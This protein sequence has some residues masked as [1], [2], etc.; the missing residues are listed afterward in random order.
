MPDIASLRF[1]IDVGDISKAEESLDRLAQ[2]GDKAEQA[3]KDLSQSWTSVGQSSAY[4]ATNTKAT[5]D[6]F[7]STASAINSTKAAIGGV[8]ASFSTATRSAKQTQQALAQLPL[9]FTDIFTSLASGQAP[10]TV[11]IQQGGQIKDSFGGVG[12]ALRETALYARTLV[13]PLTL[14]AAAAAAL[15]LAYKQGSEEADA[16]NKAIITTGNAAGTTANELADI[17]RQVDGVVGTQAKAADVLAQLASTGK[18]AADQ[19]ELLTTAAVAYEQATGQAVED[20]I[21]QYKK[22][23]EDPVEAALKLNE[24]LNFLTPAIYDQIVALEEQGRTAE[25]AA[26]A[27]RAL[28]DEQTQRAQELTDQLGYIQLA[29]KGVTDAAKEGWDAILDVG[30]S[31]TEAQKIDRLR[32]R[33]QELEA[34]RSSFGQALLN[35]FDFGQ[36]LIGDNE[37]QIR[38]Q[39]SAIEAAQKAA[40][41]AADQEAKQAADNKAYFEQDQENRKKK[42][43]AEKQFAQLVQ[44]NLTK[45]QKLTAEIANIRA[46]GA[47]AGVGK[48]EIEAQVRAAEARFAESLPKGRTARTPV[49]RDDAATKLLA[50]LREQEAALSLQLTTTDKL[51]KAEQDRVKFEQQITD[52]KTKGQLTAEQQSLLNNQDAIRAQ[53]DKNVAIEQEVTLRQKAADE[54][55]KLA[56]FEGVLAD[57]MQRA[58]DS[59]ALSLEGVGRGDKVQKQL[60]EQLKIQQD[61]ANEQSKLQE[62]FN[63]GDISQDLYDKETQAL[64]RALDERLQLQQDYYAKDAA[65]RGD[66]LNGVTKSFEDYVDAANDVSGQTEQL[67]TKALGGIEDEFVS[68]ATTGKASFRD[69]ADSILADIAR[70]GVRTLIGNAIGGATGQGGGQGIDFGSIASAIGSFF[71]GGRATGGSVSAGKFYEVGEGN[72]PELLMAGG[73][74]Y[75]I[76]GNNGAVVPNGKMG[77]TNN[78]TV[79]LS[80]ISDRREAREA[81]ATAG[82]QIT[83]AVSAAARFS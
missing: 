35:P 69:L 83:R 68:L 40:S 62:Q 48:D 13:N 16:F 61:F 1:S 8:D 41:E 38:A 19:F 81:A 53:L 63:R 18:I 80:G 47:A 22:L 2:S 50:S 65:A 70:I 60:Q 52:L 21:E 26:V 4:A 28:A 54:A 58:R 77:G 14:A 31:E 3:A 11:L 17:A 72:K 7:K 66:W 33:L 73:K 78:I 23:A 75:L 25:A 15:A 12:N 46:T 55:Q 30:R 24:T 74:Q 79:N 27:Q 5:A 37:E 59:L 76:P 9:Q 45:E 57:N 64:A 67:F 44:S 39:I 20:S 36:S 10:L 82:R 32:E 51:T 34:A 42:A 71:G 43:E 29:W 6:A 49:F 56:A